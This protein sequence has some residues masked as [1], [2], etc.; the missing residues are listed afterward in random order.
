M[1]VQDQIDRPRFI[2]AMAAVMPEFENRFG[3][4]LIDQIR[5]AG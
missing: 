2:A 1:T 3:R 5:K 4:D